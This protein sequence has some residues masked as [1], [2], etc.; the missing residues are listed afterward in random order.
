M[1]PGEYQAITES[2]RGAI[3][4]ARELAARSAETRAIA[5]VLTVIADDLCSRA[6]AE[7]ER[8]RLLASERDRTD[9]AAVRLQ[10]GGTPQSRTR[11]SSNQAQ[12]QTDAAIR[13]PIRIR[14]SAAAVPVPPIPG[15]LQGCRRV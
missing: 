4:W 9:P 6:R 13:Q 11:L 8:A 5:A 15:V 12:T 2:A 1:T 10:A 7:R 3:T 14:V